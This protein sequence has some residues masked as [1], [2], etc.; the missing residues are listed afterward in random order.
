MQFVV[1][2][3]F[4]IAIAFISGAMLMWPFFRSR[5]AGPSLTTLQVTQ[6]INQK[7]AQVIDVRDATEFAKGSLPGA[8]NIPAAVA[9]E[10]AAELKKDKPVIVIDAGGAQAGRVASQLRAAGFADVF[11]LAGGLAAWRQAGLPVR[12]AA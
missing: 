6:M 11:V 2:N 7:S 10:R 4:L 12:A 8:K 3:A 5:A 1:D 9:A